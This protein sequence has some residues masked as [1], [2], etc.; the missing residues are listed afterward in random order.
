MNDKGYAYRY[1]FCMS[2]RTNEI[3]KYKSAVYR[4]THDNLT[5]IYTRE[6]FYDR[7][8]EV[9]HMNPDIR[10]LIICTKI[11]IYR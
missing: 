9:I 1:Y 11:N 7:V 5:G 3:E 6:K 2:D 10:R 4:A 8:N